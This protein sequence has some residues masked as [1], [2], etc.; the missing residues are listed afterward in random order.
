MDIA[1]QV[2]S[3]EKG[4]GV[5]DQF[6]LDAVQKVGFP[7]PSLRAGRGGGWRGGGE[8]GV[9]VVCIQEY[10]I[11]RMRMN[12][13]APNPAF[14][15][16]SAYSIYVICQPNSPTKRATETVAQQSETD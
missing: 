4:F 3:F 11:V 5:G 10:I 14:K 13:C 7:V 1:S 9:L 2:L 12:F 16:L 8:G 15:A 6:H